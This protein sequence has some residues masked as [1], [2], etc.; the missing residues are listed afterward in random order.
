MI[1]CLNLIKK[2]YKILQNQKHLHN[3]LLII[4]LKTN[5]KDLKA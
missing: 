2:I 4:H 3:L 5:Q 1:L